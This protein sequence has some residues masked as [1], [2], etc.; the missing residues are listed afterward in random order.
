MGVVVAKLNA[1]NVASATGDIPQN[2]NFAI[3]ASLVMA[4]PEAQRIILPE[5][6]VAD[7]ALST[8]E[9]AQRVVTQAICTE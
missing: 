4:F 2:V 6:A 7:K 3:K 1:V 9:V 5:A 8:P